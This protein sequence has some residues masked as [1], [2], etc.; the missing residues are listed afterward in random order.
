MGSGFDAGVR[1]LNDPYKCRDLDDPERITNRDNS[2]WKREVDWAHNHGITTMRCPCAKCVGSGRPLLL[3]TI[4][5]HLLVNQRSSMF[6]CGR[7]QGSP[8]TLMKSG[9]QQP[10]YKPICQ[11]RLWMMVSRL[12]KCWMIYLCLKMLKT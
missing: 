3:T 5:A 7:G 11:Q 9:V 10:K 8:M 6:R 1:Q 4:K 2:L 12:H